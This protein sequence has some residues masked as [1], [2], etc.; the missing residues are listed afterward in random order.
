MQSHP[1]L[2]ETVTEGRNNGIKMHDH[3]RYKSQMRRFSDIET[4]LY[5]VSFVLQLT[6]RCLLRLFLMIS[7][8]LARSIH[9]TQITAITTSTLCNTCWKQKYNVQ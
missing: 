2:L 5:L 9:G 7:I 3:K 8:G 4:L 1:N 6:G